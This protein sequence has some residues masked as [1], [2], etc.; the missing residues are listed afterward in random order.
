MLP[1]I[2]KRTLTLYDEVHFFTPTI[3][4]ISL[5][6]A[7]FL[8]VELQA[9]APNNEQLRYAIEIQRTNRNRKIGSNHLKPSLLFTDYRWYQILTVYIT[10]IVCPEL[11]KN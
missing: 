7:Y 1:R 5:L 9:D 10:N 4:R 6:S 8:P 2:I 3:R 11:C